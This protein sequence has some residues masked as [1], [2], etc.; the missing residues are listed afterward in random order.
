MGAVDD[1]D[2]DGLTC[3][4]R[5]RPGQMERLRAQAAR[6]HRS[7]DEV[8]RLALLSR[9]EDAERRERVLALTDR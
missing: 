1:R 8:A 9:I 6:A 5:V 2:R 7:M 3:I 4:R